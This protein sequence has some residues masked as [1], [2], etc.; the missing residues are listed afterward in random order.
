M[1]IVTAAA[2]LLAGCSLGGGGSKTTTQKPLPAAPSKMVLTSPAFA[3]NERIPIRFTCDGSSQSPPLSWKG[4]PSRAAELALLLDDPD[5]PGGDFTHWTLYAMNPHT[6]A[7]R[8]GAPPAGAVE[9]KNSAGHNGY[10]GPCPPGGAGP[11]RY[12]F[13][14]YALSQRAQLVPGAT[15]D[16]FRAAV[17]RLAIAKGTLVGSYSR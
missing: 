4:V 10:T 7:I 3:E 15:P 13:T 1:A 8:A 5:A 12:R 6:T 9:G 11:H 14:L 16:Q 17:G 2:T